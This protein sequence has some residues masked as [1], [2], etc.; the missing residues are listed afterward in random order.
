MGRTDKVN[1]QEDE[2]FA[3]EVRKPCLY[4]KASEHYKDKRKVSNAWK[5]VDEQ[6]GFEE[7]N[8]FFNV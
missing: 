7:G 1:L 8:T 6:L 3:K 5:L 4:Y 2:E